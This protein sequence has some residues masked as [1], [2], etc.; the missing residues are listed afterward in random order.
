MNSYEGNLPYVFI[1]YAHLDVDRVLPIIQHL[2]SDGYRIWYDQGIEAGTAWAKNIAEHLG[3]ASCIIAFISQNYISSENCM[4]EIEH[5]KNKGKN[6]LIIYLDNIIVPEWFEMRHN[7]TQAIFYTQYNTESLFYQRIF[8]A[9][10]LDICKEGKKENVSEKIEENFDDEL[11][12]NFRLLF[13]D[14]NERR[15]IDIEPDD[16]SSTLQQIVLKKMEDKAINDFFENNA[17]EIIK[18]EEQE[19]KSLIP[20]TEKVMGRCMGKHFSII[21][22]PDTKTL[23]YEVYKCV[24]SLRNLRY[25]DAEPLIFDEE[26]QA[27]GTTKRTYYIE[28]PQEKGNQLIILTFT[29]EAVL[30]NNGLLCVDEVRLSRKPVYFKF[31]EDKYSNTEINTRY[32][33]SKGYYD[34][35]T[36]PDEGIIKINSSTTF[37]SSARLDAKTIIIDPRK[38]IPVLRKIEFDEEIGEYKAFV[39]IEA[40]KSYFAFQVSSGENNSYE[41][42]LSNI[43]LGRFYRNGIYGY[44]KNL[45]KAIELFEKENTAEGYYE[46][47]QIFTHNAELDDKVLA[48]KYLEM[49]ANSGYLLA[50]LDL[51]ILYIFKKNKKNK[52][53]EG[54]ELINKAIGENSAVAKFLKAALI[55]L[56]I[57]KND[58]DSQCFELYYA[59]AAA[60]YKPAQ[61]RLS[62]IITDG[63]WDTQI[64]RENAWE[65]FKNTKGI[66]EIEFCLGSSLM[67]NWDIGK[68][69]EIGLLYLEKAIAKGNI[70][71]ANDLYNFYLNQKD[72][73]YLKY[74]RCVIKLGKDAK[75]LNKFCDNLLDIEIHS[76][77]SDIVAK[78]G[79]E[80]A[81]ELDANYAVAINNLGWMYQNARGTK[82]DYKKALKLFEHAAQSGCQNAYFHL[83]EIYEIKGDTEKALYWYTE[84][85]NLGNEK[86]MKKLFEN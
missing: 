35:D 43:E 68:D 72:S 54:I 4:D 21:D 36:I 1:S 20:C 64:S 80:K 23:I 22:K 29:G 58:D 50:I 82:Q 53:K 86:C 7:R 39:E 73:R 38:K 75:F 48:E 28:N 41:S 31:T 15:N 62:S 71:A 78:T 55:E 19:V 46:I 25:F 27:D 81:I 61:S 33:F 42:S 70:S 40:N 34:I 13:Y 51:A 44:K 8:E 2:K 24:D 52:K 18:A 12:E 67:W 56:Q 65:Y 10:I 84:G 47:S 45:L 14:E 74:A 16:N 85:S 11:D 76:D 5:A 57:E 66:G 77:E 3:R 30:I 83:G 63:K 37:K 17:N 59:A 32:V 79:F 26:L 49:S 60:N 69:D 6:T 9:H